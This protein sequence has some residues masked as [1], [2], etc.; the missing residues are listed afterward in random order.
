MAALSGVLALTGFACANG[1]EAPPTTETSPVFDPSKFVIC[2]SQ[3]GVSE[4]TYDMSLRASDKVVD[5]VQPPIDESA[6]LSVRLDEAGH[7]VS[8]EAVTATAPGFG[9]LAAAAVELAAPDP[10][11]PEAIERCI[12]GKT[13]SVQVNARADARCTDLENATEWV[14]AGRDRILA[15]LDSPAYSG[16]PGTGYAFLRLRFGPQGELLESA[17]NKS[18]SPELE[19]KIARAVEAAKPFGR[20]PNWADCF[21]NQPVTLKIQVLSKS[22]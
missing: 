15:V 4:Y 7:V 13:L 20:P 21:E 1:N 19:N 3:P 10:P 14:L 18:P 8:A 12:T 2:R 5:L 17:V 6:T 11:P 9:P 16:E 22:P